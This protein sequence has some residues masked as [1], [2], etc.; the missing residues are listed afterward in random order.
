MRPPFHKNDQHRG[1]RQSTTA[2]ASPAFFCRLLSIESRSGR[3]T[4]FHGLYG[5]AYIRQERLAD[6]LG[7]LVKKIQI[8]VDLSDWLAER[9]ASCQTDG[10]LRRLGR[11]QFQEDCSEATGKDRRGCDRTA[12]DREQRSRRLFHDRTE[13]IPEVD[14]HGEAAA[15]PA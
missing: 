14:E 2:A 8:P 13:C 9:W 3:C 1:R 6:L 5:N 11:R 10:R 12:E 4:G 7:E 15:S